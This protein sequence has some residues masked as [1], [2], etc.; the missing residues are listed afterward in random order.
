MIYVGGMWKGEEEGDYSVGASIARRSSGNCSFISVWE[1]D[2]FL[3]Q[4]NT[5]LSMF[6]VKKVQ[7]SMILPITLTLRGCPMRQT[8]TEKGFQ[9]SSFLGIKAPSALTIIDLSALWP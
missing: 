8:P 9:Q 6:N 4:L 2:S 7:P 3:T 1:D 5:L